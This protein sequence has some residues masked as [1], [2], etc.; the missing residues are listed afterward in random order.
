VSTDESANYYKAPS[1]VTNLSQFDYYRSLYRG[2]AYTAQSESGRS[3]TTNNTEYYV[4]SSCLLYISL[5]NN[6]I[7]I[8]IGP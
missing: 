8:D 5:A 1:L 2:Y 6:D 3:V 4:V 7:D